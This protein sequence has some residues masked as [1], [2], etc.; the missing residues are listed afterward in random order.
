MVTFL[1]SLNIYVYR[2]SREFR[3]KYENLFIFYSSGIPSEL[4]VNTSYLEKSMD[5]W[6]TTFCT[7]T[8]T[9]TKIDSPRSKKNPRLKRKI[10]LQVIYFYFV[11]KKINWTLHF[12]DS[13][14]SKSIWDL[15]FEMVL[16]FFLTIIWWFIAENSMGYLPNLLEI[17]L[18]DHI[19]VFWVRERLQIL[20]AW[21]FFNFL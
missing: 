21:L 5:F 3:I 12:L 14:I 7:K 1:H 8:F 2:S 16:R 18:L 4:S 17:I 19:F 20:A 6:Q 10:G 15:F 11:V 13:K 9:M